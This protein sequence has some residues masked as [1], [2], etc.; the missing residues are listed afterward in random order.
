MRKGYFYVFYLFLYGSCD[1]EFLAGQGTRKVECIFQATIVHYYN[2]SN[3]CALHSKISSHILSL[4][5]FNLYTSL[6]IFDPVFGF[7]L[8][9]LWQ[10][11]SVPHLLF[12]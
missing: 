3:P 7:P 2:L 12:F 4:S 5:I 8:N 9:S 10:F 1:A 6:S 11:G